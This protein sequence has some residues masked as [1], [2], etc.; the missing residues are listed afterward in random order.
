[1]R[2]VTKLF[3]QPGRTKVAV[4]IRNEEHLNTRKPCTCVMCFLGDQRAVND[5]STLAESRIR[6]AGNCTIGYLKYRPSAHIL[7]ST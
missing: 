5:P 1:M 4:I 6:T 2:N 3:G 7:D